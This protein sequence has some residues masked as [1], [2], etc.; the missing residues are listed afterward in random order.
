MYKELYNSNTTLV[1]VKSHIVLALSPIFLHSNTTL[2][3]V[4]L[5][6][7]F[8]VMLGTKHSNTTLVKVK[9]SGGIEPMFKVS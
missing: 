1:K 6:I 5:K 8:M 4:K 9:F 7:V 3:K 2:V